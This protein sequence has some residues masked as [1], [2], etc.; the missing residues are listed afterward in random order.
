MREKLRARLLVASGVTV[1]ALAVGG[2][3]VADPW[4][5]GPPT[6][7]EHPDGPPHGYCYE[8]SVN[9]GGDIVDNIVEV[10]VFALDPTDATVTYDS[11]CQLTGVGE[12]DV[13]WTTGPIAGALANTIC[14]DLDNNNYCDQNYIKV[15]VSAHYNEYDKS[16]STCHELGHTVGLQHHD[17]GDY[18]MLS[19]HVT[20]SAVNYRRYSAHAKD[21][22]NAWF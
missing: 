19:G 11:D 5:I 2:V 15:Y 13:V 4:A 17:T 9:P 20:S 21:H 18:C 8:D 7:G 3:A 1:M 6:A 10:E 12:T 22:I 14:D 16:H